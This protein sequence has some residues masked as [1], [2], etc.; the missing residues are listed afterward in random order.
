[1]TA[2]GAEIKS[3]VLPRVENCPL[4][5]RTQL[6][7]YN[8]PVCGGE[9]FHCRNCNRS[10]DMIEL[11]AAAWKLEIPA[12]IQKLG[13]LGL[14]LPEAAR[15]DAAIDWYICKYVRPREHV[16]AFWA[17]CQRAGYDYQNQL[18]RSLQRHLGA[19]L[20]LDV[21]VWLQQ[22]GQ[23]LGA[24]S[25]LALN[26]FA[27]PTVIAHRD[28]IRS[29]TKHHRGRSRNAGSRL[30]CGCHWADALLMPFYDLPGRI[31]GFMAL[32]PT[33]TGELELL[34]Y[35]TGREAQ[36]DQKRE[37]GLGG[38]P[39]ALQRPGGQLG[40]SVFVF[41]DPTLALCLQM[42]HMRD[43]AQPLPL[44][45]AYQGPRTATQLP[46]KWLP[47]DD[48][49]VWAPQLNIQT[50]RCAQQAQAQV[51]TY[52]ISQKEI[53][54]NMNHERGLDWLARIKRDVVPWRVAL[55]QL[56]DNAPTQQIEEALTAL[57]LSGP[58]LRQFTAGCPEVLQRRILGISGIRRRL[59]QAVADG[60]IFYES[61]GSWY[62]ASND[63]LLCDAVIHIEQILQGANGRNYYK[64]I[65]RHDGRTFSFLERTETLDA[66]L[67]SWCRRFLVPS[68]KYD[69]QGN[70]QGVSIATAFHQPEVVKGINTVG[71]DEEQR[72]FAFP[73]FLVTATGEVST[74]RVCLFD[75]QGA[76]ACHLPKPSPTLSDHDIRVLSDDNS[77]T[78]IFW[79]TLAGVLHV[80][81]APALGIEAQSLYLD[82]PGANAVGRAVLLQLDC[83]QATFSGNEVEHL[84]H[85]R[86]PILLDTP[87]D[88]AVARWLT[89]VQP[90]GL[91]VRPNWPMARVL[92][93]R[94]TW[95][96]IRS[97]RR[98]G[99]APLTDHVAPRVLPFYLQDLCKR[100]LWLPNTGLP[101]VENVLQDLTEWFHDLSDGH[102]AALVAARAVLETPQTVP[103]WR[104]FMELVVHMMETGIFHPG[105]LA[106]HD[107][108][109]P[110]VVVRPDEQ[111]GVWVSQRRFSEGVEHLAAFAPDLLLVTKSLA[112]EEALY[113]ESVYRGD[114]GWR[115]HEPWWDK[116]F[117]ALAPNSGEEL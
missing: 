95:I 11:S 108:G 33:T 102:T 8:D 112:H 32:G 74:E 77:E 82:G 17:R 87:V 97:D 76:P 90:R 25:K 60:R 92:G 14:P 51:S 23:F 104:H 103:A 105:R 84:R 47:A 40:S 79:A 96:G 72:L 19:H 89:D 117:Q 62:Y 110:A 10:G 83:P 50:I 73:R 18:I 38:L 53:D 69:T 68:L 106:S 41:T 15:T 111:P 5:G 80:A 55:R 4:C 61:E 39:A 59:L 48:L 64:G 6:H 93:L 42:R 56:L 46:W 81:L 22:G 24:A 13:V 44:V 7:C 75:E 31:S 45:V 43:T 65:V 9:W 71:W 3:S 100:K 63:K 94:G 67:F 49:I 16:K 85:H 88:T 52:T 1:M 116:R 27:A 91:F 29:P 58:A 86:W 113:D 36:G 21:D 28:L 101:T 2:L 35:P 20:S 98:L 78:Q 37:A 30:L 107:P 115:I 99:S 54:C 66:G 57:A 109:P 70:K 34:F 114:Y 12:A 26:T